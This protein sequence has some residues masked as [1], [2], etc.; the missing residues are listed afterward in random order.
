GVRHPRVGLL[1]NGQESMRGGELVVQA[2]AELTACLAAQAERGEELSFEFLGNLEGGDVTAGVADVVVTDGFTGNVALKLIEGVSQTMLG[3]IRAAAESSPRAQLGGLLLRPALRD[4]R[5]QIDP[6]RQGGAYLLGLRRL[7]VVPH[8]R[9]SRRGF[10]QAILRAAQ[11]VREDV[12]GA[13]DAEL[14]RAGALRGGAAGSPSA[15][16]ASLR[17][18]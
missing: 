16:D 18:T 6:E 13:T 10:A 5:E 7:G 1:S 11:G 8:G 17:S 12:V 9:F 3:A 15:L 14:R 4:F 2:H